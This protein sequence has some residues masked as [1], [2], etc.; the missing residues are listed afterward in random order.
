MDGVCRVHL[1]QHVGWLPLA[2]LETTL[3]TGVELQDPGQ[4]GRAQDACGGIRSRR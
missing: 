1:G 4:Q 3:I 2:I